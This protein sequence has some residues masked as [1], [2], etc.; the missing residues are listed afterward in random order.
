MASNIWRSIFCLSLK[1]QGKSLWKMH[2]TINCFAA[3]D[4][5]ACRRSKLLTKQ[6]RP[7]DRQDESRVYT[8]CC[9]MANIWVHSL[10]HKQNCKMN[11]Y[12]NKRCTIIMY[13]VVLY[14]QCC[15]ISIVAFRV[16]APIDNGVHIVVMCMCG[17]HGTLPPYN[18]IT[19]N[20]FHFWHY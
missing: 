15:V 4:A 18:T 8:S 11:Y 9:D 3:G 20:W 2:E 16:L 6:R 13:F 12:G 5:L 10:F 19:L 14:I 7:T 1:S 17:Q